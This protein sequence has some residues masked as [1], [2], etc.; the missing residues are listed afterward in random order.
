MDLK[1]LFEARKVAQTVTAMSLVQPKL[2]LESS[3]EHPPA[4]KSK[5]PSKLLRV[6]H[7]ASIPKTLHRKVDSTCG[8]PASKEIF[9]RYS[10]ARKLLEALPVQIEKQLEFMQMPQIFNCVIFDRVQQE[11]Q[12]LES[13]SPSP[14]NKRLIGSSE[15][16]VML[17]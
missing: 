2:A 16:P 14:M 10:D 6:P 7:Y 9:S 4:E 5:P 8:V 11:F 17:I 3:Y 12:D 1:Q 15:T 13:V